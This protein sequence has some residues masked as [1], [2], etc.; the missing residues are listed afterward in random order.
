MRFLLYNGI[1]EGNKV[2]NIQS[3]DLV[4]ITEDEVAKTVILVI[5]PA[6]GESALIRLDPRNVNNVKGTEK[7]TLPFD[8]LFAL[9][10]E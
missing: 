5:N 7:V 8:G 4:G 3:A 2:A 1:A 6:T 10:Q 9:I